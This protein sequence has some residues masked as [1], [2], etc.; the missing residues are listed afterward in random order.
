MSPSHAGPLSPRYGLRKVLVDILQ[1]LLRKLPA[2]FSKC[3]CLAGAAV[4]VLYT[5]VQ[6]WLGLKQRRDI[7]PLR[8]KALVLWHTIALPMHQYHV[9]QEVTAWF[10]EAGYENVRETTIPSL[11]HT[12]FGMLGIRRADA[13]EA[14]QAVRS[15]LRT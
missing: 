12:G 1:K 8:H 3:F 11:A 13:P 6:Q 5:R 15:S 2:S 4:L 14:E 9:P 10:L 7:G